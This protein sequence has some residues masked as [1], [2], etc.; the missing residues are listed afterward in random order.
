MSTTYTRLFLGLLLMALFACTNDAPEDSTEQSTELT[1]AVI[2]QMLMVGFRGQAID[3]VSDNIKSQIQSGQIGHYILFDYDYRNKVYDRNISNRAQVKQ[4]NSDLQ[5]LA[6]QSM[7]AAIDQEGGRVQRL[8]TNYGF[9]T[10]MSAA[11]LGALANTD[12]TYYYADLNARNMVD[13][14]LNVNFAPVV[15]VAVNPDNP[16]IAKIERS[17]SADPDKVTEH[18]K[19]WVAAHDKQGIL[20]VLKHFPGHGSSTSD[21]HQGFTDISNTWTPKELLPYEYLIQSNNAIGVMTAHVFNRQI[22]SIYPATLS[23]RYINNLLRGKYRH[24]GLVFSDDLHMKA[25]HEMFDFETIILQ[26]IQASVDILVFGNN[27]EYDE[28]IA[29]KTIATIRKLI[30]NGSLKEEQIWAAHQRIRTSL[31]RL[32]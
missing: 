16:V 32:K 14:G 27:L 15:D 21:S 23:P 11:Y 12:S 22:D 24:N 7:F 18:A 6:P 9:D 19:V 29:K 17:F 30:A 13:I 31:D 26:S 28:D 8:K 1:D 3:Q 10:L 2:G 5:A 4:L 25:V 20:S